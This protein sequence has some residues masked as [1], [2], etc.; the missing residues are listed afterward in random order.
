M[1]SRKTTQPLATQQHPRGM[2]VRP[3][4]LSLKQI[5]KSPGNPGLSLFEAR[6]S[7]QTLYFEYFSRNLF[8]LNI[9]RTVTPSKPMILDIYPQDRGGGVGV[10]PRKRWRRKTIA[11]QDSP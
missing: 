2:L 1:S 10:P 11:I 5:E 6:N 7:E 8:G 4:L 9:L 3:N